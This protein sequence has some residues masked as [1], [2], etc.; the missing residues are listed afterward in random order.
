MSESTCK[1]HRDKELMSL[2][3]NPINIIKETSVL[4]K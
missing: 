4:E 1:Q 3:N 2:V